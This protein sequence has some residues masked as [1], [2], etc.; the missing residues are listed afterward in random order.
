LKRAGNVSAGGRGF[1]WGETDT[2][3]RGPLKKGRRQENGKPPTEGGGGWFGRKRGGIEEGGEKWTFLGDRQI[4]EVTVGRK[5]QT[6][7][8]PLV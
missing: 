2:K 4:E 8:V 7:R 6:A 1:E 5:K 3:C